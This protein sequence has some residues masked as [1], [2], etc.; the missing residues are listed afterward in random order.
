[1]KWTRQR[2]AFL[3]YPEAKADIDSLRRALDELNLQHSILANEKRHL[4]NE[5]R[6]LKSLAGPEEMTLHTPSKYA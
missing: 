1:V 4:V 2:L 6:R 5:N 3:I